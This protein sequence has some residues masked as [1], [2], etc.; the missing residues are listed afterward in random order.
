MADKPSKRG[1]PDDQIQHRPDYRQRDQTEHIDRRKTN[2]PRPVPNRPAA[3]P[4]DAGRE[5]EA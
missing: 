4:P 2:Q 1:V 3:T 5:Y